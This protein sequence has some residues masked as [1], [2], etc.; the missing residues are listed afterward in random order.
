M[1][2]S[3]SRLLRWVVSLSETASRTASS[4][5]RPWGSHWLRTRSLKTPYHCIVN[6]CEFNRTAY[7]TRPHKG[8]YTAAPCKLGCAVQRTSAMPHP[9]GMGPS[10]GRA[11]HG[12]VPK[13]TDDCTEYSLRMKENT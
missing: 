5:P 1:F 11:R 10:D 12:N 4:Q 9:F 6:D 3:T 7:A 8:G 2:G 13:R